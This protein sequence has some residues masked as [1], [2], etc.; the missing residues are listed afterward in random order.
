MDTIDKNK[1]NK[2]LIPD[3]YLYINYTNSY[4]SLMLSILGIVLIF[5]S[6]QSFKYDHHIIDLLKTPIIKIMFIDN[7]KKEL[8]NKQ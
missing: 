7:F 2:Y 1:K 3:K 5:T 4:L 8:Q 6:I